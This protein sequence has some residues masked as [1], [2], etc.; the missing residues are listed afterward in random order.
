VNAECSSLRVYRTK[1]SDV[2]EVV[3][4]DSVTKSFTLNPKSNEFQRFE[5]MPGSNVTAAFGSS[6]SKDD[7]YLMNYANYVSFSKKK[8]F[9]SIKSGKGS[10]VVTYSVKD[11][12][13]YYFVVDHKGKESAKA[14]FNMS[15]NYVR[16]QMNSRKQVQCTE[17]CKLDDVTSSEVIVAENGGKGECNVKLKLP[18]TWAAGAILTRIV[19]PIFLIVPGLFLLVSGIVQCVQARN[20]R[21]HLQRAYDILQRQKAQETAGQQKEPTPYSP[22]VNDNPAAPS[23]VL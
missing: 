10:L 11:G 9:S 16:Y 4:H 17:K 23:Y 7:C 8:S 14:S 21:K 6:D 19:G 5:L 20:S 15:I 1:P 2:P 18:D 22:L 13:A 12:D 3:V